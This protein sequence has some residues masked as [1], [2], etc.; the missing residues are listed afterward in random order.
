V[1]SSTPDAAERGSTDEEAPLVLI[2]DD[3][4]MNL[5]L[6]RDV[7]RAAGFRTLEA[8]SGSEAIAYAVDRLPDVVL[9]DL[10]LPDMDGFAVAREL[11]SRA[12]T[13]GIPIVALSALPT[14]AAGV[15]LGD[16]FTAYLEKPISVERLPDQ[17]RRHCARA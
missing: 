10:R 17:V 13:S 8:A 7:L 5:K 12:P 6:V 14:A 16:D 3:N 15:R 11:R 2:V 4:V 1:S 9:L